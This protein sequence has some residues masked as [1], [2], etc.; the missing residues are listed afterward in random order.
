[1]LVFLTLIPTDGGQTI[2]QKTC[3]SLLQFAS[4]LSPRTERL[5]SSERISMRISDNN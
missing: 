1:M 3:C 4:Y 5:C 2:I